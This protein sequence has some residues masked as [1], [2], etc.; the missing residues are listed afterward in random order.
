MLSYCQGEN[1][2][3]KTGVNVPL[4]LAKKPQSGIV[5]DDIPK[6]FVQEF[7]PELVTPIVMISRVK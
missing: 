2:T 5:P 6:K 1:K 4:K 7:T 3:H